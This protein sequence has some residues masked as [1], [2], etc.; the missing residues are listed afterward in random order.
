MFTSCCPGWVRFLK[1]QYPELT[2][3][4]S[5][6]KS[7]QQ[8]FGAVSKTWIAQRLGVDPEK[9]FSISVMPCV[10]KKAERELPGMQ[11]ADA[12]DDVDLVLTTRELIRMVCSEP[13]DVPALTE[14]PF[15]SPLGDG[16]GAGVIFGATGG[17]MEAALRSAYFLATGENPPA[18]A[19]REVRASQHFQAAWREASFD[20]AGTTVR[21]AIASGLGNARQLIQ[22][23]QR[24]EAHYEFVEVMACPGGCA[25][26]GGQPV[27]GSDRE[28]AA[29]RGEVLY[30][31]DRKAALRFS[32]ENPAVQ[33]LYQE[34][35][36]APCSKKAEHLLHC[37][38]FAWQMPQNH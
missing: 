26:G 12:G 19:F 38:H 3:R 25:G 10:A 23:I 17:V 33:A 35:L 2:G 16:T 8:M 37:D 22:A 11:S 1:S 5:T 13:I 32:H 27:D 14:T 30:D 21:C 7:P 28:L 9:V 15:D 24:G 29:S 18:D 34:Y 36:E 6:A 4:L 31:L 20:L